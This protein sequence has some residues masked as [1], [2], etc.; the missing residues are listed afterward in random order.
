MERMKLDR[1]THEGWYVVLDDSG[2]RVIY[3]ASSYRGAVRLAKRGSTIG[4]PCLIARV[5]ARKTD[6]EALSERT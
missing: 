3:T 6:G 1:D 2:T 4:W 5:I